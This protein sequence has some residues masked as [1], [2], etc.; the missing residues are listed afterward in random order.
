MSPQRY[1]AIVIGSGAGGAA[2]AYRLVLAGLRVLVVEKGG[3]LPTD[4]STL[5]IR[6]V[7]HQGEFLSREPW[8]D[9]RGRPLAPEEHFNV[10]GK[11]RWY[12]AALLRF[13]EHEFDADASHDCAP[14]PI[15]FADLEPYYR[16]AER[17]LH[18]GT[19][20]REPDL[21]RIVASLAP[22]G[23]EWHAQAMPMSLARNIGHYADEAAHFD[24][25][26][27]VRGLKLDAVTALL[28]RLD[29]RPTFTL[30]ANAEVRSLV[31]L[32]SS[33]ETI[34]GVRLTD[35]REYFAPRVLL[36]AGALHSPRLLW[37]HCIANGL[38]R[39]L[40]AALSIGRHLKLH[41]LTAMVSIGTHRVGDLIRKTTVLVNERFP[42]SS[43]QPLGFDAELI[44][45]LMPKAMPRFARR[46]LA[47]RAY[48][49]FLQTE[50]GSDAR[51]RVREGATPVL[52]YDER[53][54]SAALREHRAFTRALQVALLR[55]GLVSVTKRIGLNGTA[56]ACGTLRCGNDPTS[57]VVDARGAVHGMRGLY[58]VDGSVLPRSSRVNPSL[59]IY[60]W[61]LR[62]ADL[63]ARERG[64]AG[65]EVVEREVAHAG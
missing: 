24:G 59:T 34:V 65:A 13:G 53:R 6:R 32:P 28:S 21:A 1:D 2:A 5:D 61:A 26:A 50:D 15:R 36:A 52:D 51:N 7:V 4:G 29:D 48:G 40:P 17:L 60:A 63:L 33:P 12:G 55:S 44:A 16:E 45:T 19:F 22:P 8:I 31:G 30:M 35:G 11:T 10:G 43:V 47:E 58:V 49:F 27:S 3:H 46:A 9:A 64:R 14:W 38:D 42:H 62:A 25:F 37:R 57:S 20:E 54:L 39:E 41:L 56:H 23:S 18:V